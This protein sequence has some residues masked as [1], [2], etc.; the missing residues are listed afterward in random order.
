VNNQSKQERADLS[1]QLEAA[2][3]QLRATRQFLE[4]QAAEREAEREEWER[5]LNTFHLTTKR[6][7]G[8]QPFTII[9]FSSHSF[10]RISI[11]FSSQ[12]SGVLN[13]FYRSG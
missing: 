10:F 9:F 12:I 5:R 7:G 11:I 4:E 1:Q 8:K 3:K 6:S 13:Y 2:D